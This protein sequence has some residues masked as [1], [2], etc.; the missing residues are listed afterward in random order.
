MSTCITGLNFGSDF[1]AVLRIDQHDADVGNLKGREK[2]PTEI[3]CSRGVNDI[4][5]VSVVFGK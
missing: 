1:K 3:I 5:F 2:T 4:E